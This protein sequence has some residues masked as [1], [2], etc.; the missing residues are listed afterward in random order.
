MKTR[1]IAL[2]MVLV[3]GSGHTLHAGDKI[4]IQEGEKIIFLGDS[5]TASGAGRNGYCDLVIRGLNHLGLKVTWR[6]AGKGGHKSNNM[7]H[8]LQGDVI[9]QKPDWMTLSCG[10]NDV[11]QNAHGRGV[12]LPDYKKNI[13]A[14]VDKAQA[15]GIKVMILTAT[16]IGENQEE[17]LNQNLIPYNDF[18]RKLAKEKACLLA[19]LN[20]DHQ[21]AVKA[22]QEKKP[23]IRHVLAHDGVHMWPSGNKMMARGVLRAFGVTEQQ[24]KSIE[25]E[26]WAKK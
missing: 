1:L 14:I 5:I 12:D 10:V 4:A 6:G 21:A 18:L 16:M 9:N 24:L 25:E 26:E 19:D 2:V 20:A 11:M 3:M 8:R 13:T 22:A 15:A 17:E 7:L 23:R